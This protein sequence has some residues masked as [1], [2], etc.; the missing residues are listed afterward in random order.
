MNTLNENFQILGS[1]FPYVENYI[2]RD[3]FY[4]WQGE[5]GHFFH[6]S[7]LERITFLCIENERRGVHFFLIS[8]VVPLGQD[9]LVSEKKVSILAVC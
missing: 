6:K 4:H 2:Y 9:A 3:I 5:K 1:P 7:S 8:T